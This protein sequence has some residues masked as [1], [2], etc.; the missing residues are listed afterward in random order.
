M[1]YVLPFDREKHSIPVRSQGCD[2]E[3]L[4]N[5]RGVVPPCPGPWSPALSI[6][7]LTSWQPRLGKYSM[8]LAGGDSTAR[9][10]W[11]TGSLP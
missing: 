2:H 6:P 11:A 3:Q 5:G 4:G 10:P 8:G 1:Q 9:V 7:S